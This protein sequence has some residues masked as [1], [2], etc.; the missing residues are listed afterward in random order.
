MTDAEREEFIQFI[1]KQYHFLI[2]KIAF[3]ILHDE[4]LVDDVKQQVLI[5][6]TPRVDVLV[7]LHPKQ[8]TAYVATAARNAAISELRKQTSIEAIKEKAIENYAKGMTMDYVDFKAFEGKYGFG[9]EIWE[10]LKQLPQMDQ[11]L[12]VLKFYYRFTNEEIAKE[13]GTN[14]EQVK[15]RYMR[16]KEKLLRLLRKKGD[17]LL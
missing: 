13:F 1:D 14:V 8:V 17:E 9:Q 6:C 16:A 7:D 15:K 3:G 2:Y 5:K 4:D 12:L 11:D 10:L